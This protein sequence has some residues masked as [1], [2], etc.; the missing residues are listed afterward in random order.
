[1]IAAFDEYKTFGDIMKYKDSPIEKNLWTD[2]LFEIMEKA[3]E[4]GAECIHFE[5][6]DNLVL[7]KSKTINEYK[8]VEPVSSPDSA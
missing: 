8:L 4:N 3:I 7:E 5:D 6:V 1:M 2:C